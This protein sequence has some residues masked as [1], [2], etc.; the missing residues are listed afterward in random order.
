[1]NQRI[2]AV[3]G[4]QFSCIAEKLVELVRHAA[5]PRLGLLVGQKSEPLW[6]SA[7]KQHDGVKVEAGTE[8]LRLKAANI[9]IIPTTALFPSTMGEFMRADGIGRKGKKAEPSGDVAWSGGGDAPEREDITM[10]IGNALVV[11]PGDARVR[12]RSDVL[13]VLDLHALVRDFAVYLSAAPSKFLILRVQQHENNQHR[14]LIIH[15]WYIGGVHTLVSRVW[16]LVESPHEDRVD[17]KKENRL[18]P[19]EIGNDA[20][21]LELLLEDRGPDGALIRHFDSVVRHHR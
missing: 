15:P 19:R 8:D 21:I 1:M 13:L 6:M 12:S 3:Y 16:T 2:A 4:S 20:R 14:S 7:W 18:I 17:A 11:A 5:K 9:N 10:R